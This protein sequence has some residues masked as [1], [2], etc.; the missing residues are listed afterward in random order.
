MK[1]TSQQ[2]VVF[3]LGEQRYA[4]PINSVEKIVQAVEITPLPKAPEIVLGIINWQKQI[5]AVINIRQR[6]GLPDRELELN[7]HLIIVQTARRIVGLPVDFVNGVIERFA[8][9]V[10]PAKNVLNDIEYISG[11]IRLEDG[12]I[13]IH[14]LD[15]LL[16]LEEE[17]GLEKAIKEK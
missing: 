12:L 8:Q 16:S 4:L 11:V 2:W 6:F 7:D 1:N 5:I 9:E 15:Q 3:T 13:L 14:D 10:F 17:E